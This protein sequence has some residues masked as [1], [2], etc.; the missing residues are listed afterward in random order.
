M[1]KTQMIQALEERMEDYRARRPVTAEMDAEIFRA[2][3][4]G[5]S[6]AQIAM[7]MPCAEATVYRALRRV[8]DFLKL[9]ELVPFL[10]ILCK[11][12]SANAPNFGDGD[13]KSL[14]EMLYVAYGEYNR[15]ETDEVKRGFESLYDLLKGLPLKSI[16]QVIY[17]VCGLCR[18]HEQSGFTEGVKVG[19]RLG[20]E[21]KN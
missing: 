13:A 5:K 1:E 9:P 16:D 2:F 10:E 3:C 4:S 14:L 7:D 12:V 18:D 11:H 6:V 15:F 20:D 19:V 17:T 8:K 21:L